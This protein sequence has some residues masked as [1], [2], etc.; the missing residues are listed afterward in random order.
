MDWVTDNLA[1]GDLD[2][3]MDLAEL[4]RQGITAILCLNGFPTL[5]PKDGFAWHQVLINDGPGNRLEDLQEALDALGKLSLDHKVLV[6]CMSGTSRAPFVVS[7]F[8]AQKKG[9][10]LTDVIKEVSKHRLGTHVNPALL[11]LYRQYAESIH[12]HPSDQ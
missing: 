12:L 6:H 3:A 8:L 11:D 5:L 4:W 9:L 7:C 2:D 1:I 10:H